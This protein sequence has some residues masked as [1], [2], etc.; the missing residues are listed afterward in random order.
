MNTSPS[1]TPDPLLVKLADHFLAVQQELDELV[2][3]FAL[4]KAEARD[5]FQE[6]R[7]AFR[8]KLHEFQ[9]TPAGDTIMEVQAEMVVVIYKLDALIEK[10]VAESQ[11]LFDK[12]LDELD[13]LADRLKLAISKQINSSYILEH[14]TLEIEQLKLKLQLF[15]LAFKLKKVK[16]KDS[17]HEYM[18][19][20]KDKIHKTVAWMKDHVPGHKTKLQQFR[21]ETRVAFQHLRKAIDSLRN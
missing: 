3:Q 14:L 6:A 21:E 2:V 16:A 19:D 13:S 11:E 12:Q 1:Q 10:G 20:V 17:F 15:Q 8:S 9:Q 4:G 5:K 18:H 7:K